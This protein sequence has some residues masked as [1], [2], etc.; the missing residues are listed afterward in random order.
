VRTP[1]RKILHCIVIIVVM[2]TP[3]RSVWAYDHTVCQ[4]QDSTSHDAEHQH[5]HAEPAANA[6]SHHGHESVSNNCCCCDSGTYC[7]Q[8]CG[9]SVNV[10]MLLR[11]NLTVPPSRKPFYPLQADDRLEF[12]ERIPPFRPPAHFQI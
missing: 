12:R 10:S 5:V 3:L 9:I 11:S 1:S 7:I 8:D 6:A 4:T 2:A